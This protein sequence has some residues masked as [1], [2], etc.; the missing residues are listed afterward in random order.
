MKEVTKTYKVFKFNELSSNIQDKVIDKF[1]D[2]NIDHD[3]YEFCY[4][5]FEERLL[6]IGIRNK[7]FWFSLDRD[8]HLVMRDPQFSSAATFIEA[9]LK[10]SDLKV[11]S[12]VF[13]IVLNEIKIERNHARN[14]GH[15]I[16]LCY[17][18]AESRCPKLSSLL[19]DI[20]NRLNE[21]L[22]DT[23]SNFLS[24]L[25]KEFEYLTSREAIIESIECNEYEFLENG[26]MFR[27]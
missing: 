5:D 26:E 19:M 23:L 22:K 1:Y 20:E 9:A 13:E 24:I 2:F 14:G 25:Q 21:F 10:N 18:P 17:I 16:E 11:K 7:G 4:E 6:E 3:W 15:G 12:S 27:G 8:Y